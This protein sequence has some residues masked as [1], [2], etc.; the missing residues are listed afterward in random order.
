MDKI[1]T[2]PFSKGFS[3]NAWPENE[4]VNSTS[5]S[6]SRSIKPYVMHPDRKEQKHVVA[7][8]LE[9]IQEGTNSED[10]LNSSKYSQ[11]DE[12]KCSFHLPEL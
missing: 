1:F 9:V 5:R 8:R 12:N 11:K 6:T 4:G 10:S 3:A 7:V 2:S